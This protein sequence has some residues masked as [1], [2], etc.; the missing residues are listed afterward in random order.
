MGAEVTGREA[1]AAM[2][3]RIFDELEGGWMSME[4]AEAAR[5][6]AEDTCNM[7]QELRN[8]ADDLDGA[9]GVFESAAAMAD[10]M[11]DGRRPPDFREIKRSLALIARWGWK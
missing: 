9:R 7:S 5:S 10:A 8:E 3:V 4:A 11:A 6:Y 2:A 1:A